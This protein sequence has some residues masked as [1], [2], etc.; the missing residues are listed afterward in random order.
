VTCQRLAGPRPE[1][2]PAGIMEIFH[3]LGCVQI[4]PIRV[5]ER[6]Q[7]LVLWSR[8]GPYDPA[9]LDMLLW[10]ERQLFEYWAHAAS[11]V[12]TE[13][14][15]IH[16]AQMRRHANG[17]GEGGW[18]Q[19]LDAWLQTNEP[20][21]QH[22]LERLRQ[23]G[24]LS[25]DQFE[26]LTTASWEST[27][28]TNERN[29]S[30]MIDILWYRGN[31]TVAERNGLRKKWALLEHHLPEWVSH[32]PLPETEVVRRAAQKSLRALGLGTAKQISNHFIRGRYPGLTAVLAEL[33]KEG[34]FIPVS[35]KDDQVT[36]P[37]QWYLHAAD[38]PLLEQLQRD[39]WGSRTTLLS[40]FDNLICD[41]AR[42]E[43]MWNFYFRIEIYVPE[44]KRQYGY[45]V[46]PILHGERLIGRIDPKMDR[47]TGRLQINAVY[48]EPDAPQ[49]SATGQA[50]ATAITELAQ[51]LGAKEI[52]F[53]ERIPTGWQPAL[54]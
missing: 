28:W 47:K 16:Q 9:H 17:F 52:T 19:R 54:T 8:L 23:E 1:A 14:F 24:P 48:A 7:Y 31:I 22:I 3:D 35:I 40:P 34:R 15:P 43:L 13:D 10:Q 51:F 12:L 21:R 26:D 50:I 44:A 27:G 39:D 38:L 53:G 29:V 49:D 2:S 33:V 18:K 25:S 20:L 42:T 30:R 41:R 46:L 4:D 36:W 6:T 37:G 11:I 45:Y 32:E 5:V